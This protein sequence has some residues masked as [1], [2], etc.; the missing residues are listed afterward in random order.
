MPQASDELRALMKRWFGD[1]ID[2]QGPMKLLLS[3]GFTE[4]NGMWRLP[5][6]SHTI[7]DIEWYCLKFLHDEWDFGIVKDEFSYIKPPKA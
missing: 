3:H 4:E 7:S 5:V 2:E 1:P 6:P